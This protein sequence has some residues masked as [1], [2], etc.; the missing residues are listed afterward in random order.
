M[1]YWGQGAEMAAHRTFTLATDVPVYFC[2]P[3]SPLAARLE[4]EHLLVQPWRAGL[5]R[6][7][8]FGG[9]AG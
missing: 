2:N 9:T 3:G 7:E 5:L 4:R 6:R 8:R 1:G